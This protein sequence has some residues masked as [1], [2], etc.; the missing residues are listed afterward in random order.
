MN[1]RNMFL[2]FLFVL[3]IV[4]QAGASESKHSTFTNML[5]LFGI[6]NEKAPSCS[7]KQTQKV[8]LEIA[9]RELWSQT[10]GLPPENIKAS[11][12]LEGIRT[13]NVEKET[14]AYSCAA[15]LVI[16]LVINGKEYDFKRIPIEYISEL[17]DN[18]DEFYVT[19]TGL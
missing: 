9:E 2:C 6:E 18:K 8:I 1:Y 7:D 10:G 14:G 13:R 3:F 5:N 12:E 4:P 16:T 19:V 17:T 15:D 11:L